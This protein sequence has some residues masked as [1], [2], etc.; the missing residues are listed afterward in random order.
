MQ[1]HTRGMLYRIAF[2]AQDRSI[3]GRPAAFLRYVKRP[4]DVLRAEVEID[5]QVWLIRPALLIP[6]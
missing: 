3:A 4:F 2:N 6:F 1:Q 5:G